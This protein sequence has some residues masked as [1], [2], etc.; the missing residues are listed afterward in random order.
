MEYGCGA[1]SETVADP[2]IEPPGPVYED[3]LID[4]I[5]RRTESS[6]ETASAETGL[7]RPTPDWSVQP[8]TDEVEQPVIDL[9]ADSVQP[10]DEDQFAEAGQGEDQPGGV[11]LGELHPAE[12]DPPAA[13]EGGVEEP[14]A[15]DAR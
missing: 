3:E 7:L 13:V 4:V 15:G 8:V 14:P 5:D 11:E 1:H 6:P 10:V 2:V 12:L 9:E